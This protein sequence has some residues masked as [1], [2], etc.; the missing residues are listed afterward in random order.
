MQSGIRLRRRF[1]S[2]SAQF[3][4]VHGFVSRTAAAEKTGKRDYFVDNRQVGVEMDVFLDQLG[5]LAVSARQFALYP[6]DRQMRMEA[7]L[8]FAITEL[9]LQRLVNQGLQP[10]QFVRAVFDA[11]P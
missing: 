7:A 3:G 11:N 4:P 10:L 8:L 5:Q 9:G 2:A 6:A 1:L